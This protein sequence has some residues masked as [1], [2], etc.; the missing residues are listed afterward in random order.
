[1][2]DGTCDADQVDKALT[3]LGEKLQMVGV[4]AKETVAL[5]EPI[6]KIARLSAWV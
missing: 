4:V 6:K 3:G 2:A 1:M 5:I